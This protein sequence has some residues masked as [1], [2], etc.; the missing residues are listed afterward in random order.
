MRGW[1]DRI[2]HI[3]KTQHPIFFRMNNNSKEYDVIIIGGGVTGAGT[4]RDCALRGLRTLLVER[5][6]FAD[7]ASGRNHGLLHSGARYAVSDTESA[8][9][10]IEENMIIRKIAS[11]C[12]DPCGGLF[13]TLPE[14][15]DDFRKTFLTSCE[16]A[17]IEAREIDP[18]E[19]LIM[20]PSV[21][22]DITGAVVVPDASVDPFR[23]NALN[24][25]DARLHGAEVLTY[26]RVESFIMEGNRV[27][28]IKVL[29]TLSNERKEYRAQVTVNAAGIWGQVIA[30]MAGC[31]ITMFPAK[32][33]LLV[34]GHRVNRMVLNRCRKPSNADI[35][36]PG[37]VVTVIGTTSSRVPIS[38]CDNLTV[39]PDE[40]DILLKGAYQLS[41]TLS[42]TRLLRGY[43]GVRPLVADDSDPDG[44]N[45]SRGIVLLDH[46]KRDGVEGFITITGGKM[47]TYRLM[48]EVTTDLICTKLGVE[49]ECTTD[50]TPLP[51][52]DRPDDP[53]HKAPMPRKAAGG[54]YGTL[55]QQMAIESGD[56][57]VCECEQ[58]SREEMEYA[59]RNLDVKTID[60]LRRRTRV[61]MGVCQGTLCARRAAKVLCELF[62]TP[63]KEEQ[64]LRQNLRERW[65]GM[66]PVCWGETLRQAELMRKTYGHEI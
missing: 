28:G 31:K 16:A 29:D 12:V 23:L 10:C 55:A 33:S 30:Q 6:D 62:G 20:E 21:N 1:K 7:G 39:T 61:G 44:R 54:R 26:H 42:S 13:I 64:L 3:T 58:V 57:V 47:T 40:V 17:G 38:E 22:P 25:L 60:D 32:G 49:A 5:G 36:V 37:D 48:G 41:P 9:E 65:K 46:A 15:G 8:R 51:G 34:F 56:S 14:D 4:A 18:K 43:S 11:S 63:E 52:A 66:I 2:K 24:I 50:T 35:L 45:I 53:G 19:A 59:V 27:M